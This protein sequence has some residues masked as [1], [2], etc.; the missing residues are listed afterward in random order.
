MTQDVRANFAKKAAKGAVTAETDV[1]PRWNFENFYPEVDS[2]E[3]KADF[4]KLEDMVGGFI[5]KYKGKVSS[6]TAGKLAKAIEEY[7]AIYALEGKLG[8][9]VQLKAVQDSVKYGPAEVEFMNKMAPLSSGLQFF[10]FDIQ[11]I[12]EGD[13]AKL[14]KKSKT[15]RHYEPWLDDVRRAIPHTPTLDIL[16]Y[17]AELSPTRDWIKLYDDICVA[18]KYSFE[19]KELSEGEI[20]EIFSSDPDQERRAAAFQVFQ[21][22]MTQKAPLF[23]SIHNSIIRLKTVDDRWEKFDNPPDARHFSNNVDP[24]VVDALEKAVKDSYARVPHRFYALKAKLMG[25]DHL[26][27]YDR[28]VNIFEEDGDNYVSYDEA[29]RIV[30][31]A[32]REF[33]PQL[34]EGVEKFFDE[35]WID[36][37]LDKNKQ[38]G[39][40]AHPGASYLANP[41]VM[42]NYQGSMRDVATMAHELGHGV[43]QLLAAHEGDA[44]V[45]TPL[46]L[47][48]TA[49]VFGEMLTFKS[50]L[51]RVNND[52]QRKKLLFEKVNDMLNTVYRQISFYDFEKRTHGA[53]V[54]NGR[55]LTAEEFGKHW[56]DSLQDSYGDAIPLEKEYGPVFGFIPH[57][58]HSPFYVYA[59]AFGDALVNALYRVYEE[60]SVPDFEEKYIEMLKAG[61]TLK[62]E[63]LKEKF[64]LDITDPSFWNKGLEVI[65]ELIDELE[66]LCDDPAPEQKLANDNKPGPKPA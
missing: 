29:K 23:A 61:G 16:E 20:S 14:L 58:V 13:F 57:L 40:F 2:D 65:E 25:Q 56:I 62:P 49:S 54:E 45:S 12:A 30:L 59:Y 39:A 53:Y 18:T 8:T 26:N 38:N 34:A 50:L 9:Y 55:P 41:M 1:L 24:A 28:N 37:P 66:A 52:E 7:K 64:G 5:K 44:L 11:Q 51:S 15:L 6:L 36:A 35:G 63:D 31:E 3:Y 21:D 32:Y 46:T 43:H 4:K 19:G 27:I 47:A 42:L 17:S 60:G 33:S 10:N 22:V 48:E